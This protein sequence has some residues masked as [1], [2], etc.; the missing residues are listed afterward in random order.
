MCVR[1][2]NHLGD[3]DAELGGLSSSDVKSQL[4]SRG[5][6]QCDD[7]GQ[8]L[9]QLI[10]VVRMVYPLQDTATPEILLLALGFIPTVVR[11]TNAS[12]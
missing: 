3:E 2:R 1:V 6:L 4:S 11:C 8:K 10:V 12:S 7:S 9:R 5:L